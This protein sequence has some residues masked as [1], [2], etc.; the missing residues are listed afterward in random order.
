MPT[1]LTPAE[2]TQALAPIILAFAGAITG[3]FSLFYW[4]IKSEMSRMRSQI[5]GLAAENQHLHGN[6]SK[7]QVKNATLEARED[8]LKEDIKELRE[9]VE[10]VQARLNEMQGQRDDE[11][12]K[13]EKRALDYQ[14][15]IIKRDKENTA[16]KD[17]I[18]RLKKQLEVIENKL[19]AINYDYAAVVAERDELRKKTE[20]LERKVAAME[21]ENAAVTKHN[22]EL[23]G[24]I[25]QMQD[26]MDAM[27]AQVAPSALDTAP[28]DNGFGHK[29]LAEAKRITDLVPKVEP[30]GDDTI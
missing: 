5:N 8:K 25:R 26:D 28:D 11:R 12:R 6:L 7:A 2:T 17:E 9:K 4:F 14:D 30:D 10:E 3:G 15:E 20:I 19:T 24:K 16:L 27:K 13:A 29:L 22:G 1:P 21:A 18:A 23:D